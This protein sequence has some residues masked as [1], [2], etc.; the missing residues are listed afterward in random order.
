MIVLFCHQEDHPS[1]MGKQKRLHISK[2]INT[3]C[4]TKM[5]WY[6]RSVDFY[7]IKDCGL[8]LWIYRNLLLSHHPLYLWLFCK[9]VT[10]LIIWQSSSS[11]PYNIVI[12]GFNQNILT[13]GFVAEVLAF[14]HEWS[15][16]EEISKY[17]DIAQDV[18]PQRKQCNLKL[19]TEL[20]R[21]NQARSNCF[22]WLL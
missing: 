17:Q 20:L 19:D 18:S 21:D 13:F 4:E 16:F 15:A 9:N 7:R 8:W 6:G 12:E 22:P 1:Q 11:H 10:V 5:A 2:G 14:I 3:Y